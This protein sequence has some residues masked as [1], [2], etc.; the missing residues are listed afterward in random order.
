LI[1]I[2]PA[3][4]KNVH[5]PDANS[6][7]E[8]RKPRLIYEMEDFFCHQGTKTPNLIELESRTKPQ[9]QYRICC[10]EAKQMTKKVLFLYKPAS[11]FRG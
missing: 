10:T 7:F 2:K 8:F 5:E 11:P 3:G 6:S 1:A 4:G 9:I